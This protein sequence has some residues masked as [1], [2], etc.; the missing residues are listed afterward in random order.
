M[1]RTGVTYFDIVE[2]AKAIKARGD[3]PTVDRVRAQLGTGSKSTIA[4]LLKRWRSEMES[5]TDISGLPK[6]L[7]EALKGLHQRIQGQADQRVEE[8]QEEFKAREESI[9]AQLIE[10][11]ETASKQVTSI[12]GLEQKLATTEI[13]KRRFKQALDETE[14]ALE[15]S[16]YQREEA[17]ARIREQKEAV[18]EMRH[19]NR[20]IREHFEH[21][22]QRTASDRQ[23][24][25]DQY[26]SASEQLKSQIATL[27]E[28]LALAERKLGDQDLLNK[29]AQ[30]LVVEVNRDKRDLREQIAATQA[31]VEALT[32]QA[33]AQSKLESTRAV[34]VSGLQQQVIRLQSDNSALSKEAQLQQQSVERLELELASS[35]DRTQQLEDENRIVLQE[36]AMIQG[37]FTQLE[38]SLKSQ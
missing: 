37:Q 18:V 9:S 27:T 13:E 15:K 11:K 10:A 20:D 2:A 21:F 32:R 31:Q 26:R 4:P 25:R 30:A 14:A 28:Q 1:A 24:E 34:E 6:D 3:E 8:M 22:Q 12:R 36:K 16:E 35:R 33:E 29:Q 5:G 23:Q 38:T 17:A 19:E 7:V